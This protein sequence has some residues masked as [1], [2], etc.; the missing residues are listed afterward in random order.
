MSS[1]ATVTGAL[2]VKLSLARRC[3]N[4]ACCVLYYYI[5]F[6]NTESNDLRIITCFCL[7]KSEVSVEIDVKVTS[8]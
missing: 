2:R 5:L 8:L 6:S 7:K 3:F 1:T 4:V